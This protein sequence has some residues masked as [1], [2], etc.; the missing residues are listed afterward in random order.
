MALQNRRACRLSPLLVAWVFLCYGS[1]YMF[2]AP[3]TSDLSCAPHPFDMVVYPRLPRQLRCCIFLFGPS[4][5]FRGITSGVPF[6]LVC[7]HPDISKFRGCE[8]TSFKR[9][10]SAN[11]PLARSSQHKGDTSRGACRNIT[12]KHSV[13]TVT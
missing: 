11:G 12:R 6:C 10:Q 13:K 2:V 3:T 1:Q 9:R 4:L 7:F 8:P 5:L